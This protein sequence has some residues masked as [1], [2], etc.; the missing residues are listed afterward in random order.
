MRGH[1]K[2]ED[3]CS[4]IL[5]LKDAKEDGDDGAKFTSHFAKP[6]RNTGDSQPELLW[7]ITTKYEPISI[8]CEEAAAG[9]YQQF[10]R[11]VHEGVERQKDI[12]DMMQKREGTI[13]KWAKRAV[14]EGRIKKTGQRLLP[15]G[16]HV[17]SKAEDSAILSDLF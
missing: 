12:A 1:S 8:K 17:A 10:I 3:D 14:E 4:W 16:K 9:E 2:R 13:S 6:S 7:H 11:H 15:V 5:E